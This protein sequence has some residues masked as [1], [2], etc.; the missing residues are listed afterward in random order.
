MVY[1]DIPPCGEN[2][3]HR[4]AFLNMSDDTQMCPSVF[5]EITSPVRSCGR[6]SNAVGC[7]ADYWSTGDTEYSQVCGR[8]VAYQVDTTDGFNIDLEYNGVNGS[9]INSVYVDGISLTHGNPR[10]HIWTFAAGSNEQGDRFGCYCNG[11]SAGALRPPMFVGDNY[12]CESARHE[13]GFAF[14]FFLNDPLWDGKNCAVASCCEFNTPPW[15]VAHLPN[16]TTDDIEFRLCFD[17]NNANENLAIQ[18]IEM[19]II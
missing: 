2:G 15:F 4:I 6:P 16:P 13:L 14:G 19:Y 17:E 10:Q 3:W 9:D 18:L 1:A 11:S 8:I 5:S 12:F 7:Y